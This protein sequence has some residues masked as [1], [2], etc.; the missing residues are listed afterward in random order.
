MAV[1]LLPV[2]ALVVQRQVLAVSMH[3]DVSMIDF[4]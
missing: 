1:D 3:L 2:G 4:A